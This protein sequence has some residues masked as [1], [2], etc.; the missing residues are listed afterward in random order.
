MLGHR[1]ILVHFEDDVALIKE[2][3]LGHENAG[4][5]IDG[6][7]SVRN[8]RVA[9]PGDIGVAALR[10][11]IDRASGTRFHQWRTSGGR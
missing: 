2:C 9:K 7:D 10:F 5:E 8:G 4:H 6:Y 3:E 11:T 1:D